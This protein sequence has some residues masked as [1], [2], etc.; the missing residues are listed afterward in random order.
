[1]EKNAKIYVAGNAGLVGSA[2][3][4]GLNAKGYNNIIGKTINE[5]D[6]TNQAATLEYIT[7][8]KPDY[9]FLAAAKVGGIQANIT[10]PAD[11]IMQNLQ[12]QCNIIDA[13]YKSGVKKL[14]FLGSSCI[15]PAHCEQPMKE[16][17]LL[18]G[19]LE[20][21]NEAYAIAKIAGLRMCQYYKQQYGVDYIS[22][23]PS[24]LYGPG[25]NFDI[26][27]S[28]VVP[29]LIRRMHE[30]KINNAPSVSIW[31]SGNQYRE[32][33]YV[34][35]AVSAMIYLMENYS[36]NDFVNIGTGNDVTIK[37]L[38]YI[39]KEAV[40]YEGNIE[41]DTTKPDGMFR[42]VLDV[43]RLFE[44][45]WRPSYTLQDGIKQTYNWFLE[46]V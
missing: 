30:A 43:T 19:A 41:F 10:Y 9:I 11:F 1:M 5:L 23:M 42:K 25:D 13:A 33:T 20:P 37:Q 24:N 32:L 3:V 29:G 40:G 27:K 8:N 2:I 15:Y 36:G 45:G 34:D 35:D 12:I 7:E 6:L 21:T 14:L 31:G 4:R 38:A 46:N 44:T 17:Y 22:V 28:H 16:E 26:N 39:I 18:T